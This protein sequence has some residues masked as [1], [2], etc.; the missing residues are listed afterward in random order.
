[1]FS[2]MPGPGAGLLP[3]AQGAGPCPHPLRR[4]EIGCWK[5]SGSRRRWRHCQRPLPMGGNDY[6]KGLWFPLRRNVPMLGA[7][8]QKV[9]EDTFTHCGKQRSGKSTTLKAICGICRPCREIRGVWQAC[10]GL[11]GGELFQNCQPC[12]RIQGLFV[13]KTVQGGPG[14]CAEPREK[15]PDRTCEIEPLWIAMTPGGA[16]AGSSARS[17]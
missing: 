3:G 9:P 13:K 5:P 11:Q 15:L 10:G 8:A 12:Y 16:A 1:M 14:E 7:S 2:A 17:C 4:A 6:L